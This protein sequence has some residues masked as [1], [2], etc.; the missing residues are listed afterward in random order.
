MRSTR[1]VSLVIA[2]SLAVLSGP[3]VTM[4]GAPVIVA[5]TATE[6]L[7]SPNGD[8]IRDKAVLTL[9]LSTAARTSIRI[10]DFD[11][12]RVRTLLALA[13]RSAGTS[14]WH[15]NG[16]DDAG[17]RMPD[18]PYRFVI[19]A[20]DASMS[21]GPRE[22]VERWI[23]KSPFV[24]YPAAPGA[25][26]VYVN[27]GHGL[28]DVAAIS[29]DLVERDLNL[30]TSRRLVRMLRAAGL[31]VVVS[32]TRDSGVNVPPVDV[33]GDGVVANGTSD[34]TD[35]GTAR[36]DQANLARAD[37][38]VGLEYNAS[39]CHC[40]QGTETITSRRR[41]WSPEGI[42]LATRIQNAHLDYLARFADAT[43]APIDR[44]VRFNSFYQ[45]HP[46][47]LPDYPRP[48]LMPSFMAESLFIDVPAEAV[49]VRD[50]AVR[51]A[52]AAAYFQGIAEWLNTREYGLHYD[53]IAAPTGPV[54]PGAH[55]ELG[56]DLTN[57]GKAASA[58]WSLEARAIPAVTLYDGSGAEGT[59]LATTPLP[60]G[61][62][63]GAEI[64][65]LLSVAA[66]TE[67]GD[68]LVKLD[69]RLPSG[70]LLGSH[71]VVGPQLPLEVAD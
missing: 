43:W 30:D 56:T 13:V 12:G 47:H 37:L 20:R 32:R 1:L 68:Y 71:G 67:A 53:V 41:T 48:T 46:Y 4:A 14:E 38:A 63:P 66:P 59:L 69:V 5:A 31:T 40:G 62:A 52:I 8:G 51:T 39:G 24:P 44:G 28:P 23:A 2:A 42:D 34:K 60:D 25:I 36:N 57:S 16:R 58:G 33:N 19:G 27:P 18:G 65:A 70:E 61:L 55:F 50:P 3:L 6:Q 7:F 17:R 29:G 9:T 10:L 64:S 26:T 45:M 15:W 35:E 22:V 54:A 11:G 21:S 49:K